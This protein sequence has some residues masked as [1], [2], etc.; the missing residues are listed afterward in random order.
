MAKVGLVTVLFNSEKVLPGFFQSIG[1]QSFTDYHLYIVDNNPNEQSDALIQGLAQSN[2]VTAFTYIKN[3]KNVGVA[4]GNNQ[5]IALSVKAGTSHT[6]LLNNDIEFYQPSLLQSILNYSIQNNEAI[7]IPKIF[8]FDNKK[9]QVAGA[10]FLLYKGTTIGIGEGADDA[11]QYSIE[12]HVDFAPTCFALFNNQVF[13][14][15]GLM[16]EKYFVYYDDT[17]FMY[18]AHYLHGYEIKLLPSLHIF[19]KESSST[20][21]DRTLFSIFYGT[22]NRIYFIRKNF[23]G[24]QFLSSLSYTLVTRILRYVQFDSDQRAQLLKGLREGFKL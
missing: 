7:V 3:D 23:K 13:E 16:D 4:K 18:R 2:G 14:K 9:I 21:G 12:K 19:H 17:D 11:P 5:G 20:G 10:K 24:L 1:G 22:R 15:V 8:F 6:L